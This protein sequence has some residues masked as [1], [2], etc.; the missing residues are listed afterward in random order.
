VSRHV[1]DWPKLCDAL[2]MACEIRG[3]SL[4]AVATEIGVSSSGLT[5]L[6]QEKHL[7]GDALASLVA[8]LFPAS[9]PL[10]IKPAAQGE[11]EDG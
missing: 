7:S 8:W 4:R 1:V 6:R 5:R 9:I 3:K 11:G 10:W 2:E